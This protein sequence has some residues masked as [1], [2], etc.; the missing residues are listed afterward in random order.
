MS[1]VPSVAARCGVLEQVLTRT[2]VIGR[3]AESSGVSSKYT[4]RLFAYY[5]RHGL[6]KRMTNWGYFWVLH[7]FEH[8]C[9]ASADRLSSILRIENK[10]SSPTNWNDTRCYFSFKQDQGFV[11]S[12]ERRSLIGYCAN[13]SHP[14]LG[15]TGFSWQ[16]FQ[17]YDLHSTWCLCQNTRE[18]Y[19][20]KGS[21]NTCVHKTPIEVHQR[22]QAGVEMQWG[23]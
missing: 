8:L 21:Y 5:E 16:L 1:V 13:I 3:E 9:G 15:L 18:S 4:T 6:D 17:S 22:C 11:S 19:H 2:G 12:S 23:K 10:D 20:S 7:A 14:T